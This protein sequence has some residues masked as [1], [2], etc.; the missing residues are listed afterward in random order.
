[1]LGTMSIF[2]SLLHT[3]VFWTSSLLW[4]SSGKALSH[5]REKADSAELSK[6]LV[7]IRVQS[8]VFPW[9]SHGIQPVELN[10]IG[11]PLLSRWS[12][13]R[14]I[15]P[16]QLERSHMEPRKT[17]EPAGATWQLIDIGMLT[18]HNLITF[19]TCLICWYAFCLPRVAHLDLWK[20]IALRVDT[21]LN[22]QPSPW[23][24]P[25]A[26]PCGTK[27]GIGGC[28]QR[29][30]LF[31][32]REFQAKATANAR[33]AVA[34]CEAR[35]MLQDATGT[36]ALMILN[37]IQSWFTKGPSHEVRLIQRNPLSEEMWW[38]RVRNKLQAILQHSSR[39]ATHSMTWHQ[40]NLS[41]VKSRPYQIFP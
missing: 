33:T 20:P 40:H 21:H 15:I 5:A 8:M 34:F 6:E 19:L 27:V 4:S 18:W 2:V 39:E 16:K 11:I 26:F 1:M 35:S 29:P 9:Y 22:Q 24:H 13:Q 23:G 25:D 3:W 17:M 30:T 37:V 14:M 28:H 36:N 10:F 31:L 38:Q 32:Q 41:G 12:W 7:P